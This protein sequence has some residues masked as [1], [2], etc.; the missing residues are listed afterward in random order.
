ML[1]SLSQ[2]PIPQFFCSQLGLL[3][4][5]PPAPLAPPRSALEMLDSGLLSVAAARKPEDVFQQDSVPPEPEVKGAA[6]DSEDDQDFK[7]LKTPRRSFYTWVS[8]LPSGV[9]KPP[10]FR[11]HAQH[12]MCFKEFL[13]DV[14]ECPGMLEVLVA[15]ARQRLQH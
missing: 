8:H 13:E 3:S 14:E 11:M 6:E 2:A 7:N 12:V 9:P 15:R 10:S 1:G 4:R 5:V